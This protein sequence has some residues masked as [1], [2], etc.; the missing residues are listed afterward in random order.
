[1]LS[2]KVPFMIVPTNVQKEPDGVVVMVQVAFE[3]EPVKVK[4]PPGP[5]ALPV[6]VKLLPVAPVH[7]APPEPVSEP[8]NPAVPVVKPTFPLQTGGGQS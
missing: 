4:A 3:K 1:M 7:L 2:F 5:P 8:L 6:M